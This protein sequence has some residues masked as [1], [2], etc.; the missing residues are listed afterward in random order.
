MT[1]ITRPRTC[2]SLSK[3]S[4]TQFVRIAASKWFSSETSYE[5]FSNG[6]SNDVALAARRFAAFSDW[7]I[8]SVAN[9]HLP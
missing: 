9:P 3:C 4:Y 5:D 7:N 1:I 8:V 2:K 6:D